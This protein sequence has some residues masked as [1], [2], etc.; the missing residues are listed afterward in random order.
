MKRKKLIRIA[1]FIILSI[2]LQILLFEVYGR[3]GGAKASYNP[4]ENAEVYDPSLIR[5]NNLDKMVG[6]CD[7]MYGNQQI[8]DSAKY[9]NI[10]GIVVRNRFFH[11]YSYYRLGQNFIGWALA[12]Y[13]HKNLSAIV[14]PDDILKHSN[15][16]C[17][18]QSII[19][20]LLFMRKGFNVR[21]VG[22]YD[23]DSQGGHFCFEVF[24]GNKWHF[25]DPDKEPVREIL[26]KHNRPSIAELEANRALLDSVY[27]RE[28]SSVRN[29]YLLKFTYGPVNKFP[30][31]KARIYQ[32][33]TKLLSWTL[34]FWLIMF[35]WW[36]WKKYN[37]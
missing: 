22:F 16:A 3:Y 2:S 31:P 18:Q 14:L 19:G 7:S 33:A 26:E 37:V 32:Y 25:F 23:P 13:I 29:G 8:T 30:A 21:K 34:F 17:S 4:Y 35:G 6:Y 1:G 24:Y 12:P 5:L 28:D 27:Y 36:V 10:V 11:G 9:A 20:M 15:A